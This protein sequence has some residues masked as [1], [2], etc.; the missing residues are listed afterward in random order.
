MQNFP[1]SGAGQAAGSDRV[2][3]GED[4]SPITFEKGTSWPIL[5]FLLTVLVVAVLMYL[6][7]HR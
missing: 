2:V 4:S 6:F 3:D 5:R 1:S 7:L